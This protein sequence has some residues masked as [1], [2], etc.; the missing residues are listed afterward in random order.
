MHFDAAGLDGVHQCCF[1]YSK[2]ISE[3]IHANEKRR[4]EKVTVDNDVG[5]YW[6]L[7][8]LAT[9][10]PPQL[11]AKRDKAREKVEQQRQ[12]ALR[13]ADRIRSKLV[14]WLVVSS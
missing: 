11:Q 8:V 4:Q 2:A 14:H 5:Q 6:I 10:P 7:Y 13:E 1:D 12:E 9:T 3:Q